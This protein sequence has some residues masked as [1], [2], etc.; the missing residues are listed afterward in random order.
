VRH[1]AHP[2]WSWTFQR[3]LSHCLHDYLVELFVRTPETRTP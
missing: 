2:Q 1:I 3:F